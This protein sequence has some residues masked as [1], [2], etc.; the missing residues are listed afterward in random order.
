M[1]VNH[2]LVTRL[3]PSNYIRWINL[4]IESLSDVSR[5]TTHN[6]GVT[7]T[8]VSFLSVYLSQ[9][10]SAS[11]FLFAR[12]VLSPLAQP[13]SS[14]VRLLARLKSVYLQFST[15]IGT[16]LPADCFDLPVERSE[17]CFL[18]HSSL[19]VL[20]NASLTIYLPRA[21]NVGSSAR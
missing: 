13:L 10:S 19:R 18:S 12:S 4:A 9:P 15:F 2:R 16:F 3:R 14:S 6:K 11:P 8:L 20:M 7:R 17:P 21:A 1:L 5:A